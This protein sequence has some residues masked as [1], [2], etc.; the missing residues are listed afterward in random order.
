MRFEIGKPSSETL[1]IIQKPKTECFTSDLLQV[2]SAFALQSHCGQTSFENK[3][4]IK[5]RESALESLS[6]NSSHALLRDWVVHSAR[7]L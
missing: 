6:I 2:H 5:K 1:L 4:K 3:N 7:V